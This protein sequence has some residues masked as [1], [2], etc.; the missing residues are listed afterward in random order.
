MPDYE[1]ICDLRKKLTK[2]PQHD[3]LYVLGSNGS[4]SEH[5][6]TRLHEV[7]KGALFGGKEV[8]GKILIERIRSGG[9]ACR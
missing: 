2:V 5:G 4:S 9:A 3:I 6:E 8:E 1:N 7:H